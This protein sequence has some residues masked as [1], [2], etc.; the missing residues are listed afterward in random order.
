MNLF[1]LSLEEMLCFFA[2]L[3][4]YSVLFSLLPWIGDRA[5]PAPV[6]V[7]LALSVSILVFPMLVRTGQIQIDDAK[8]WGRPFI[9]EP[10]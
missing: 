8:Q 7:L 1:N 10:L 2:V 4:R 9:N 5:V 3:I 6:K